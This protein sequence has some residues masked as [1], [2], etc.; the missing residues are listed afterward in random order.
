MTKDGEEIASDSSMDEDEGIAEADPEEE[1]EEADAGP[2]Q[3]FIQLLFDSQVRQKQEE[4]RARRTAGLSVFKSTGN[5]MADGFRR[6]I[7]KKMNEMVQKE[8]AKS[9]DAD[10]VLRVEVERRTTIRERELT[11][12]KER[13]IKEHE[14]KL[15]TAQEAR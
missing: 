13:F 2:Q 14:I 12:E 9:K 7:E 11:A 6:M 8:M 1:K 10:D 5:P 4:D 3:S 15:L